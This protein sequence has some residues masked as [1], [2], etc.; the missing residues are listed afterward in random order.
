MICARYIIAFIVQLTLHSADAR[1]D[2]QVYLHIETIG[3]D[4]SD[5]AICAPG[6]K[7]LCCKVCRVRLRQLA[8]PDTPPS[9]FRSDGLW[10]V[11]VSLQ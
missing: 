3:F 8:S 9:L 2:Q 11:S 1:I 4:H 10:P 6:A 7:R 5:H